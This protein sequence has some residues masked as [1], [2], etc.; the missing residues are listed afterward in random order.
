MIDEESELIQMIQTY[1]DDFYRLCLTYVK[2]SMTAMDIVQDAI[3][4]AMLN[5]HKLKSKEYLKTWFY[6]IL[7]NECKLYIRKKKFTEPFYETSFS[8]PTTDI[9]TTLEVQEMIEKLPL[10]YKD[11]IYLRYYE[12]MSLLE[13]SQVLHM[14][15]NSVK[16][17][18]YKALDILKADW[19]K[20]SDDGCYNK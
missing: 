10:K 12:D 8:S 9:H 7:I 6:R 20:G 13:I 18:L 5:Y 19:E 17:R 1:Q 15:V 14:N 3:V 11:I 4:K 2:D 16:T